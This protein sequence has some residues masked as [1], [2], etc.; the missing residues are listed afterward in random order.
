MAPLLPSELRTDQQA[1]LQAGDGLSL[2]ELACKRFGPVN[3][4]CYTPK[5]A[6]RP[7]PKGEF[8]QLNEHRSPKLLHLM[9][10]ATA[11]SAQAE[12]DRADFKAM[13]G[14]GD[15]LATAQVSALLKRG[16]LESDSP[17]GRLRLGVPQNALRFYFPNL[18][19]EA[20]MDTR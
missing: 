18:W 17:H 10:G 14:L 3:G 11:R 9:P 4:Y 7:A 19:P 6:S 12:L 15:R 2:W 20:E 16:L 1:S 5:F 13:L 8:G